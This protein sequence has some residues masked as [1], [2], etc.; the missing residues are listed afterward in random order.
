MTSTDAANWPAVV[1][2]KQKLAEQVGSRKVPSIAT[3]GSTTSPRTVASKSATSFYPAHCI[4]APPNLLSRPARICSAKNPWRLL[5]PIVGQQ[6]T[7][8][9]RQTYR[10][11]YGPNNVEATKAIREARVV[12]TRLPYCFD[13]NRNSLRCWRL[14]QLVVVI[15][16][17][18]NVAFWIVGTDRTPG[19]I[20]RCHSKPSQLP[21]LTVLEIAD[22]PDRLPSLK[23]CRNNV[24]LAHQ[25][26]ITRALNSAKSI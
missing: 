24:I 19:Q 15:D 22:E 4:R 5:L 13:A 17:N 11:Q 14:R 26:H 9:R 16:G 12:A 18:Q 7:W 25:H 3:T 20:V 10:Y 23:A 8:Q 6:S 2:N 1:K 21:A